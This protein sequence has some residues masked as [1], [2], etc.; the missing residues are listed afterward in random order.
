MS[1]AH[2]SQH[3]NRN[4]TSHLVD[5]SKNIPQN[6]NTKQTNENLKDWKENQKKK[7]KI[8]R[9]KLTNPKALR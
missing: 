4:H 5:E 7:V 6:K 2:M 1:L 8:N 9:I 3:K